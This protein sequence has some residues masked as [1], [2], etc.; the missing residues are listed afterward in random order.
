V[1]K[2]NQLQVFNLVG[3]V[4]RLQQPAADGAVAADEVVDQGV[5]G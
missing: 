1:H 5:V 2:V 3:D 4:L